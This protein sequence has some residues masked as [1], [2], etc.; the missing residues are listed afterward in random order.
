MRALYTGSDLHGNNNLL[1][2][3]DGQ[4]KKIFKKSLPNDPLLMLDVL[5]PY[6]EDM[7][8]I[9]VESTYNWY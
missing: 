9:V 1:G 2:I 8:G 6:K 4:G 7:V 5:T 3:V